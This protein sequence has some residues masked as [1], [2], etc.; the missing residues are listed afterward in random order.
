MRRRRR[1]LALLDACLACVLMGVL[2]GGILRGVSQQ[3]RET[4]TLRTGAEVHALASALLDQEAA[5]RVWTWIGDAEGPDGVARAE[6]PSVLWRTRLGPTSGVE[7]L[8]LEAEVLAWDQGRASL[9]RV[10]LEVVR[11]G[12]PLHRREVLAVR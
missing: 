8:W 3:T 9:A 10:S 12:A 2:L 6:V 1:G 5:G 7:A 11:R 4:S